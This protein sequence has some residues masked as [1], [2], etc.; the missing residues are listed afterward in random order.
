MAAVKVAAVQH[1]FAFGV[2]DG[3]VVGAVE[4]VLDRLTQKRQ[5]IGQHADHVRCAADRVTVLQ[6][7]LVTRRRA[8]SEI[9]AASAQRPAAAPDVV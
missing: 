4:F 2:D 9:R 8:R 5:G 7:V 3:I 6:A 1:V